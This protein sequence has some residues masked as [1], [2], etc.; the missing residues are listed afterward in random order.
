MNMSTMDTKNHGSIVAMEFRRPPSVAFADIVEEFDIAFR[1]A[2][3]HT[4]ALIW[5]GDNIA[6]VDRECVR[7]G[8]GW[9]AGDEKGAPSH[10]VVA[11]GPAPE[12]QRSAPI[13]PRCFRFLAERIAERTR[14][15]LPYT[16]ALYGEASQ[17]ISAALIASTFDLLRM[18]ADDRADDRT[19]ASAARAARAAARRASA[20]EAMRDWMR[21]HAPHV[22]HAAARAQLAQPT[23]P[24]RLTI[25]TLA[26][27]L[28]LQ[29]PPL[30]AA[31]FTYTML[32][33]IFPTA[34]QSI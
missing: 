3:S 17:P 11:V 21:A 12:T 32:R 24:L 6:L 23:E 10:L 18:D 19:Q 1:M 9:L 4:R 5:E 20:W 31:M 13:D 27:S 29:V 15:F 28:C 22:P 34:A 14:E 30:G 25:H 26:L 8:L 2:D 16:A 7:V 33:D